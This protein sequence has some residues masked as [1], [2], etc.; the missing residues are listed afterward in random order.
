MSTP[1]KSTTPIRVRGVVIEPRGLRQLATLVSK[2]HERDSSN[3]KDGKRMAES[4]IQ[5]VLSRPDGREYESENVSI[6][7]ENGILETKR[8]TEFEQPPLCCP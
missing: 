1:I 3:F 7:A 6:L 4:S 5:F 2:E 8:T